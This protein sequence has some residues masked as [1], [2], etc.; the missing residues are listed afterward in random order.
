MRY[1]K[2][3]NKKVEEMFC[4]DCKTLTILKSE[5]Q[6]RPKENRKG[7]P[8]Q[9]GA[10]RIEYLDDYFEE[11]FGTCEWNITGIG[12][13]LVDEIKKWVDTTVKLKHT[14]RCYLKRTNPGLFP[15]EYRLFV[16]GR[17]RDERCTW[18]E[19]FRTAMQNKLKEK[20]ILIE[21]QDV[22]PLK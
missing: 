22:C 17:G 3:C 18:C 19:S 16:T 6:L 10:V 21:R 1:C 20:G 7:V 4:P 14:A 15:P 2:S 12:W 5:E 8:E 13:G 9:P 11:G